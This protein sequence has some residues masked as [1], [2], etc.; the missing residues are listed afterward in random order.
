MKS[1]TEIY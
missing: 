1:I